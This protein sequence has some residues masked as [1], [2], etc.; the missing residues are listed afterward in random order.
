MEKSTV[1][2]T[3]LLALGGITLL[4]YGDDTMEDDAMEDEQAKTKEESKKR[5]KKESIHDQSG[6]GAPG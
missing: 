2:T 1:P 3:P 4:G 5:R 6:N